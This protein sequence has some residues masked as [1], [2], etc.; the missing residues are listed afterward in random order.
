MV[1]EGF[2]YAVN[3][4]TKS[5]WIGLK[6]KDHTDNGAMT[7]IDD[8]SLLYTNWG[9]H[10]PNIRPGDNCGYIDNFMKFP[11]DW[12]WKLD[13]NCNTPRSFI[14]KLDK[15]GN[16]S[17]PEDDIE[18]YEHLGDPMDCD[19]GWQTHVDAWHCFKASGTKVS[20]PEAK[21]QCESDNA[22][23][24]SVYGDSSNNYV[25]RYSVKIATCR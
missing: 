16:F 12:S 20:Y 1:Y 13:N 6:I 23:L 9:A 25:K 8:Y 24:A 5:I 11:K 4:L 21:R 14:C 2:K 7:W 15:Y 19:A 17:T 18:I 22:Y 10:E 3:D